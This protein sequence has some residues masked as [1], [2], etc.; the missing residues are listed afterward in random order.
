MISFFSFFLQR[1]LHFYFLPDLVLNSQQRLNPICYRLEFIPVTSQ[2]FT[3]IKKHQIKMCDLSDRQR[4]NVTSKHTSN[5]SCR[6]EFADLPS[7]A[8]TQTDE[9]SR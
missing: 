6:G 8:V 3:L 4:L 5:V 9:F 2:E 7:D 1:S